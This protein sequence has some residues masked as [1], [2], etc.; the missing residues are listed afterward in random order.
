MTPDKVYARPISQ[1][2]YNTLFFYKVVRN[3]S[4]VYSNINSG[5]EIKIYQTDGHIVPLVINENGNIKL[6]PPT[7]NPEKW[8]DKIWVEYDKGKVR[9]QIIEYEEQGYSNMINQ[10][11]ELESKVKVKKDWINDLKNGCNFWED[12]ING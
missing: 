10:I 9:N 2:P 7:M 6:H 4:E 11:R 8:A 3:D 1:V 5:S 12:G